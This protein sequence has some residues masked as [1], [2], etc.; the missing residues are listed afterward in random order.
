M[1]PPILM[2]E[3]TDPE[4]LAEAQA[5]R[6]RYARNVQWLRDHA[7]GVFSR[8]RGKHI[9]IAGAELFV[10]D[11][12]EEAL[13]RARLVHPEDDGRYLRYIPRER[14][15]RIYVYSRRVASV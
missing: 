7:A 2:K 5:R 10:G 8:S 15:A 3:V 13:A 12:A 11:T 14:V 9:C 4:Q 1:Q 6:E